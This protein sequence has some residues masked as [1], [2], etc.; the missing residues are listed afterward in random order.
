MVKKKKKKVLNKKAELRKLLKKKEKAKKRK[1]ITMASPQKIV[2]QEF[3][4]ENPEKSE[5][6]ALPAQK[7]S[8]QVEKLSEIVPSIRSSEEFLRKREAIKQPNIKLKEIK[9]LMIEEELTSGLFNKKNAKEEVPEESPSEDTVEEEEEKSSVFSFFKKKAPKKEEIEE[10]TKEEL[11]VEEEVLKKTPA[12]LEEEREFLEEVKK[13]KQKEKEFLEEDKEKES[14]WQNIPPVSISK[15]IQLKASQE[16]IPSGVIKEAEKEERVKIEERLRLEKISKKEDGKQVILESYDIEV[17]KAKVKVEIKKGSSG[18]NYG[19]YVPEIGIATTSLLE[20]IRNELV[21]VTSISMQEILDP[22]ALKDIKR[23]F[24][25]VADE[26]LK[27]KIPTIEPDIEEFLIGKL[28]QDMLGLGE[29]EFLVNDPSLEEIVIPSSKEPIRVFHKKYGWLLTNLRIAKENEIVNYSNIVA[30]RVGR[31]ITV[32]TPLLDAHLVTGDRVNA[33]LYPISTKG[34]TITIRKFARDPY[35][36]IDLINN[37]TCNLDI[38]ALL[39]L[40][41]EYEMNVLISGGTASGKTVLLNACMPFIPPNHR[42]VSVEDTR[43]LMLPDFLY[44]T[45]LVTR[46]PNPEGK[47]EV[48]ML[49]LLIN[50]L[51]MRPDRI[52]LGEMRRKEEAMVLFEAMHTG[53][54]VYATVH[55]DSAAET[56]SR[57]TNPPLSV[58]ANLLRAVNLNAV[59]FRDRKRGIRRVSQVAEFQASQDKAEANIIYRLIPEEDRIIRH[60]ESSRFFEDLSRNTGMTQAEIN[61][62]LEGKQKILSWLIKNKIRDLNDFGRVMNLYYTD[63]ERLNKFIQRNDIKGVLGR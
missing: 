48:S 26:L 12:E 31:Q 24:M 41:I 28:M 54:S 55:A 57:L 53:H 16:N 21:S 35:T 5:E 45:P 1:I 7:R 33:V 6:E 27:R 63:K 37:K 10:E 40:A 62:N 47:G 15:T 34:N 13:N 19:L 25:Q 3:E 14:F 44:W 59:M 2:P 29:I 30:R 32:L 9:P 4:K 56:I 60:S 36:I 22:S 8:S 39:W 51:R 18:I 17:D 46:T 43:E 49:D 50:S 20:D 52:V 58:P 42:I 61:K 11:P 23:K 38:A